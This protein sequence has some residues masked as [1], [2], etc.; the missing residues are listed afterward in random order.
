MT[1]KSVKLAAKKKQARKPVSRAISKKSKVYDYKSELL[2]SGSK[3]QQYDKLFEQKL[4]GQYKE[5]RKLKDYSMQSKRF[6]RILIVLLTII[7]IA[8]LILSY[9]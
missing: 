1:K 4:S 8:L 7:L 2:E 6:L 3:E 9:G 5:F